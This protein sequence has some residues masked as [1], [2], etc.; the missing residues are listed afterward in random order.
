MRAFNSK[1]KVAALATATTVVILTIGFHMRASNERV[2][3]SRKNKIV[4]DARQSLEE[5]DEAI[6][7]ARKA[8][9]AK[10]EMDQSGADLPIDRKFSDYLARAEEDSKNVE[11][12]RQRL[13]EKREL[14]DEL[15]QRFKS[16]AKP[17]ESDKQALGEY[18]AK[19]TEY[20][21]EMAQILSDLDADV[22]K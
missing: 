10:P 3:D 15:N 13:E 8:L 5:A 17:S 4:T 20:H 2:A 22:L 7:L 9:E 11:V 6:N 16:L 12:I 21:Q 19:E 14:I 18:N 1:A